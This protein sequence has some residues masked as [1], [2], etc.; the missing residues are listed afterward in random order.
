MIA[1]P[2]HLSP[3]SI[4][5]LPLL[6][7]PPLLPQRADLLTHRSV[8]VVPRRPA[9]IPVLAVV[10]MAADLDRAVEPHPDMDPVAA[11]CPCGNDKS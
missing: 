5:E 10:L 7:L 6:R 3:L 2:I 8:G 4:C 11:V 9:I 1:K